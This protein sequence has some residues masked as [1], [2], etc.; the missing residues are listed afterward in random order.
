MQSASQDA[1]GMR[2]IGRAIVEGVA[3]NTPLGRVF[4]RPLNSITTETERAQ[5]FQ[6]SEQLV[7]LYQQAAALRALPMQA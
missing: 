3:D 1:G 7:R 4:L 6:K 2:G 5:Q